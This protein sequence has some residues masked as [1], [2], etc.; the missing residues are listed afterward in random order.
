[1]VS[2]GLMAILLTQSPAGK[3]GVGFPAT[4]IIS[5]NESRVRPKRCAVFVSALAWS[6]LAGTLVLTPACSSNRQKAAAGLQQTQLF[7]TM[8]DSI[9]TPDGMAI[10]PNGDLVVACPNYADQTKP[11]CL[12]YFNKDRQLVKQVLVP[13][14]P[15]TGVACPMGIEFGPDGDAYIC[16]NQAW[17][18]TPA[19]QGKGRM[20][21]LRIEGD[22][23]VKT[24][25]VVAGMEHPNGCRIRNG[26]LYV[27]MSLMPKVKDPSGLLV[28]GVYSF[29]LD[30]E[31]ITVT[32]TLDDKNLV[33][34]FISKNPNCQYGTDGLV[35]D[36][37]GNLFVG[38]FGD[39]AIYKLT[40]D[41]AGKL[42]GNTLFAK[43]DHDYALLP[44]SPDFLAK[45]TTA[46]MR[47]TDG[48]CIDSDDNIY[49]ADFSNNAIAK[50]TPKGEISIVAQNG[51][52]SGANGA[53]NEPGEPIVWNGM[54]VVTNFDAVFGPEHPDKVNTKHETPAT[55][56][57]LPLK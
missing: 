30:D 51:E 17:K 4:G 21:R 38:I 54:L 32:N 31:N 34:T 55:I 40:F 52:L 2:V 48:I 36:S 45:S 26:R 35:F 7:A 44:K 49:V 29:L 33:T 1:M 22:K 3:I 27:T 37:K 11:A 46:K 47:T 6:I 5:S 24:T 23:V 13:P 20:L 16:D 41:A 15:D 43:T 25:V 53:L 39:G 56:S 8:P 28:S 42:T 57:M 50:V 19:G 9:P 14:H 10:A 18:G 12:A